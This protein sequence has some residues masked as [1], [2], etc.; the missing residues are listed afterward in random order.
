MKK[1]KMGGKTDEKKDWGAS[2][3]GKPLSICAAKV[4]KQQLWASNI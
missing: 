4:E 2:V 1:Q 3:E